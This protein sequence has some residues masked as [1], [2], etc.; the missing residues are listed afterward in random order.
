MLDFVVSCRVSS[1]DFVV[2]F[3][4]IASREGLLWASWTAAALA[5]GYR[6][7]FDFISTTVLLGDFLIGGLPSESQASQPVLE[8]ITLVSSLLQRMV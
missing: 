6:F 5:G 7:S 2:R 3:G 4:L 8:S 1:R